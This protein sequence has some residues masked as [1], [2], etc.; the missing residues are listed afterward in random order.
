M[1][2]NQGLKMQLFDS[3]SFAEAIAPKKDQTPSL[4]ITLA[5]RDESLNDYVEAVLVQPIGNNNVTS[6]NI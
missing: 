4:M 6:L 2:N 1:A 5:L 3:M